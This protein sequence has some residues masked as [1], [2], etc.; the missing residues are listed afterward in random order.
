MAVGDNFMEN[1][2]MEIPNTGKA[3]EGKDANLQF[4][5]GLKMTPSLA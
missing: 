5:H 4:S 1:E 2:S 3:E